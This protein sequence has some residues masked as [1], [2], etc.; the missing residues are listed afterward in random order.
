[1]RFYD[2]KNNRLIYISAKADPNFWDTLWSADETIKKTVFK[3]KNTYV[4]KITK[5]YLRP[6]E[7]TILEG[8]CGRGIY[9]AS[10]FKNGYKVIGIDNAPKTVEALN[11]HVP[12]LDI[13]YGDVHKLDFPDDFFAGYWSLGVIEHFWDGYDKIALEMVRVIKKRGFLF[14]QFPCMSRA[15]KIKAALGCYESYDAENE[16]AGFY[17]FA[18]DADDVV[19]KMKLYGFECLAKQGRSSLLGLKSEVRIL[20]KTLDKISNYNGRNFFIRALR[21][22]LSNAFNMFFN[23]SILLVLRKT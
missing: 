4:S 10:L 1:M 6:E 16:L 15:R 2:Q 22:A 20:S 21:Y 9:V 14:L 17:Q 19:E 13:R 18:L 12:E 3:H 7:G 5:K 23:H 11:K 8:G